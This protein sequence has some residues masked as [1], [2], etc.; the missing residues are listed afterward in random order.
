MKSLLVF[1]LL[2]V[3]ACIYGQPSGGGPLTPTPIGFVEVL[4]LGALGVGVSR[5]IKEGSK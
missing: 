5:K 4:V 1:G 2:L 3:S